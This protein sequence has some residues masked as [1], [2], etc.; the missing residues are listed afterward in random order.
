MKSFEE[1]QIVS[2]RT[3]GVSHPGPYP[4]EPTITIGHIGTKPFLRL[5][6]WYAGAPSDRPGGPWWYR[7]FT[8]TDR[9]NEY[10]NTQ[11][12]FLKAYAFSTGDEGVNLDDIRPPKEAWVWRRPTPEEA[13]ESGLGGSW[14]VVTEGDRAAFYCD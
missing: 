3:T 6:S 13:G 5:Y 1:D 11:R 2:Q 7:D 4:S 14:R 8:S 9:L 12:Y 10:L